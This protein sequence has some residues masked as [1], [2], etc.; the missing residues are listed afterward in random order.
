M[1]MSH[2]SARSND[3][4]MDHPFIST[5]TGAGM[6]IT[7]FANRWPRSINSSWLMSS[8]RVAPPMASTSRPDE[9]DLPLPRQLLA[10]VPEPDRKPGQV[11]RSERG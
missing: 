2:N 7:V 10:A 6:L 11:R 9:N 5:M 1:R 4:P 8:V 3:P